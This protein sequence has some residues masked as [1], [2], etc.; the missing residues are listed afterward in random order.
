MN[1][2]KY[3]NHSINF[4]LR[5]RVHWGASSQF[6][7][8]PVASDI[9]AH[10]LCA[11]ATRLAPNLIGF[12][13]IFI[14]RSLSSCRLIIGQL[15]Q[16]I[17]LLSF[18]E[19][20]E[21]RQLDQF[22]HHLRACELRD[23]LVHSAFYMIAQYILHAR[24]LGTKI[25]NIFLPSKCRLKLL[26]LSLYTWPAASIYRAGQVSHVAAHSWLFKV[27][28][29]TPEPCKFWSSPSSGS[30]IVLPYLSLACLLGWHTWSILQVVD[31]DKR[32]L[33]RDHVQEK[34][35]RLPKTRTIIVVVVVVVIVKV[36]LFSVI[37]IIMRRGS[38]VCL[39]E[40][41]AHHADDEKPVR[42]IL[43]DV[44]VVRIERGQTNSK[45]KTQTKSI[46]SD[47]LEF[48][49]LLFAN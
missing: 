30:I 47:S 40:M 22:Y 33:I 26:S 16:V 46:W 32:E 6:A 29:F 39:I 31:N 3:T 36:V 18:N 48:A 5:A 45:V 7:R 23:P 10:E 44:V 14:L 42:E 24:Q 2:S 17:S 12:Y 19:A 13:C 15:L 49:S 35:S 11:W 1:E 9:R 25:C 38:W 4:A 43:I 27:A 34:W 28:K 20:A 41:L 8:R 21:V 37:I